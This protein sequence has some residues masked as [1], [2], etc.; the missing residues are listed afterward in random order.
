MGLTL[1]GHTAQITD[2]EFL[3][4]T[5]DPVNIHVLGSC[6]ADG[7]V[8]LWFLN[9]AKDALGID[10][11]LRLLKK[12]SFYSLRKSTTAF[13]SRIRLTGTVENGTMVLVPNDGSNCRIVTFSCEPD[14]PQHPTPAI[15]AP[16]PV[17]HLPSPEQPQSAPVPEAPVPSHSAFTPSSGLLHKQDL[18][19]AEGKL[20]T[21]THI[22]SEHYSAPPHSA[23]RPA[24]VEDNLPS[25]GQ[26]KSPLNS[27]FPMTRAA[28]DNVFVEDDIAEATARAAGIPLDDFDMHT[29]EERAYPYQDKKLT[30]DDSGYAQ[31]EQDVDSP[32]EHSYPYQDEEQTDY[33][34]DYRGQE[35]DVV[36]EYSNQQP[37]A[38]ENVDAAVLY[39]HQQ[40][41]QEFERVEA[42]GFGNGQS[43]NFIPS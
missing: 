31:L 23:E 3:P 8:Y 6:D 19:S 5:S 20:A 22:P 7:V 18:V 2:L 1:K 24:S 36:H 13:Y 41:P 30:N 43:R 42:E 4:T 26:S 17:L 12:Y 16:G 27:T 39:Q 34:R 29:P 9:V 38:H 35:E 40:P 33:N 25:V 37:I 11:R 10:I 14:Q 32:R 21:E 28:A 15:G